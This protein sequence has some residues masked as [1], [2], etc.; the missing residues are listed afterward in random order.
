VMGMGMGIH[1]QYK[2]LI[3]ISMVIWS[4]ISFNDDNSVSHI[5]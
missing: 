5:L 1:N 3:A 2:Q 4:V